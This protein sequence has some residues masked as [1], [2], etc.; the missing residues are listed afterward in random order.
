MV[1]TI[2]DLKTFVTALGT[3]KNFVDFPFEVEGCGE[4]GALE[5]EENPEK[6]GL[7]LIVEYPENAELEAALAVGLPGCAICG[8]A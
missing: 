2:R 4:L 6:S 5:E 1:F 8:K 3:A 7:E